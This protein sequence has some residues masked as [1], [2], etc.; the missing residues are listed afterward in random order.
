[1]ASGIESRLLVAQTRANIVRPTNSLIDGLRA[2]GG[3][4]ALDEA[5]TGRKHDGGQD[6]A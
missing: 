2:W 1:M 5:G 6:D 3:G 4:P